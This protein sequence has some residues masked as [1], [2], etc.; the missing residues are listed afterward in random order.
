MS[1]CSYELPGHC[2][3]QILCENYKYSLQAI[4]QNL[5]HVHNYKT[6]SSIQISTLQHTL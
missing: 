2:K 4:N 1:K 3:L 5:P 6:H